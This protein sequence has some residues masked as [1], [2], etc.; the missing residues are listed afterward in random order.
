MV[1]QSQLYTSSAI[2]NGQLVPATRSN[3]Y[4]PFAIGPIIQGV[5]AGPPQSQ[6]TGYSGS[7]VNAQNA[8]ADV[9]AANPFSLTLSPVP[10]MIIMFVVGFAMLRYIH[11][12]Y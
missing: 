9:A 3:N 2:V 4:Y 10:M 7:Y 6:G 12:R 8:N 5:P 11:Y 1:A